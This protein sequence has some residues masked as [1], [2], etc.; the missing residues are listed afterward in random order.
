M[1]SARPGLPLFLDPLAGF[2]DRPRSPLRSSYSWQTFSSAALAVL[3][4]QESWG[5]SRKSRLIESSHSSGIR[6]TFPSNLVVA[7]VAYLWSVVENLS[8]QR[9][10][11][12]DPASLPRR[13]QGR[14]QRG[15]HGDTHD[16]PQFFPGDAENQ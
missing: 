8:P 6:T 2:P 15:Q 12:R 7:S 16:Q 1:L 13:Q 5:C 9:I 14:Q 11:G 10:R 4:F 3:A